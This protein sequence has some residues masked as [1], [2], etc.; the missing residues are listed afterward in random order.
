MKRQF[1]LLEKEF[2]ELSSMLVLV[3]SSDV[4]Q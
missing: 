2:F 1:V 4:V 3:L